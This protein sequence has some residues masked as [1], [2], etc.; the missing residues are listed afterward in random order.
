MAMRV[1]FAPSAPCCDS[2]WASLPLS[3]LAPP[4]AEVPGAP[5]AAAGTFTSV[6]SGSP[7]PCVIGAA[8]VA[9]LGMLRSRRR[10]PAAAR[11]RADIIVAAS[12]HNEVT[13]GDRGSAFT[14]R[15]GA[16]AIG[17]AAALPASLTLGKQA[18]TAAADAAGYGG[19]P[20]TVA[21][22]VVPGVF[23]FDQAYGVPGLYVSASLPIRMTVLQLD[24][25]GFMIY[26]PC[27][28][29]RECM[30]KFREMGLTDV[31]YI[32]LGTIAIEHKYYGPEWA[33]MFPTAEVWICPRTF[34]YPIDFGPYVPIVGFKPSG[35]TLHQIPKD[36]SKAPWF[37]QGVDHLQLTVDYAPR[38][39]FE[40]TVLYHRK[41][42]TFVCTDML[43]GLG[44]SP[45]EILTRSP[46]REGLLYFARNTPL[47]K[48][49]TSSEAV[50]RDGYQKQTL[51]ICDIN[52]R[53]LLS[54]AAGDLTVADEVSLALK[55]PQPQLGYF[56][57]YPCDWQEADSPCAELDKRE[58]LAKASKSPSCRPGWRGE[59]ARL[60]AGTKGT[61]F[62]VPS[63]V[64]ELQVS[65]DPEA[66]RTFAEEI[67]RRWPG[68][69]RVV[70]SHF[71]SPLPAS[72]STVRQ[73]IAAVC[74]GAPGPAAR[75]ADLSA[76]LN[77][78]DYLEA[79]NLVYLPESGRGQWRPA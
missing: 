9:A 31:R 61:G 12:S 6:G 33:E 46:Y 8:T 78:R 24:G 59:W 77:F 72:A 38:T 17:A 22:E 45:P 35:A 32:V 13:D 58:N 53:S 36:S 7:V 48:I 64:A 49:D 50:L 44:D 37:T 54:V 67:E 18:A 3:R 74:E 56:G 30:Q 29:T 39:V 69:Q 15:R 57:W 10:T 34:S 75:V 55:A 65:R 60:A 16:L 4:P 63:F 27:Q 21:A 43:A 42:G 26:N 41:S 71:T 5:V 52:P 28:P 68:I 23:T 51:L 66:L 40:E 76:I 2:A 73:A 19:Q 14:N 79:N 1:A 62:Q 20:P 11:S 25:G 47:E 70:P